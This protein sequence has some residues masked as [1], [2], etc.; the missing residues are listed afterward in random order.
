MSLAIVS[1]TWA[2]AGTWTKCET[3]VGHPFLQ[4]SEQHLHL[5]LQSEG[6][7]DRRSAA[8]TWTHK[9]KPRGQQQQSEHNQ[10][11]EGQH[12]QSKHTNTNQKDSISNLITQKANK[13]ISSSNLSPHIQTRRSA[14]VIWTHETTTRESETALWTHKHKPEGQQQASKHT[15]IKRSAAEISTHKS[16]KGQ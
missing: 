14:A 8:T 11:P 12:Q 10:Q 13:K 6:R 7:L 15:T 1:V 9:H 4:G 5:G 16:T 2:G 3:L